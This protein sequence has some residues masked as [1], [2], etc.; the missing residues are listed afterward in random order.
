MKKTRNAFIALGIMIALIPTFLLYAQHI[1]LGA[2]LSIITSCVCILCFLVSDIIQLVECKRL[3]N[4]FFGPLIIG[5]GFLI[6]LFYI[7]FIFQ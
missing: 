2:S 7:I 5:I 6:L 3:G 1:Y 4:P